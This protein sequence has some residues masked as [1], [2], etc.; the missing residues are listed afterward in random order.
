[1]S[2]GGGRPTAVTVP[3]PI[4]WMTVGRVY[5]G[6]GLTGPTVIRAVVKCLAS[7]R[8]TAK[9][10]GRAAQTTGP[11]A[12]IAGKDTPMTLPA[13]VPYSP[14]LLWGGPDQCPHGVARGAALR[15]EHRTPACPLCRADYLADA[16]DLSQHTAPHPAAVPCPAALRATFTR[17]AAG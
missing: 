16:R 12:V 5:R 17:R 4:G 6:P 8:P 7:Q 11:P 3:D 15:P 10:R 1:V 13:D 14:A 9:A 2:V